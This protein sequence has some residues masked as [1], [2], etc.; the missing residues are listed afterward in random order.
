METEPSVIEPVC[1]HLKALGHDIVANLKANKK[2]K[3]AFDED[4]ETNG[5]ITRKRF[6]EAHPLDIPRCITTL[7]GA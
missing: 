7:G 3:P 1:E 2:A 4:A 6:Y 5:G